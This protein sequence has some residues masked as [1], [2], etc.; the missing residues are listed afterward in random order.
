MTK[1]TDIYI[2]DEGNNAVQLMKYWAQL[3]S[4]S[5]KGTINPEDTAVNVSILFAQHQSPQNIQIHRLAY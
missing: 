2:Q 1:C 4:N 5:K 3:L